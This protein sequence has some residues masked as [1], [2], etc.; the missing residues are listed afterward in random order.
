MRVLLIPLFLTACASPGYE[1]YLATQQAITQSRSHADT[2]RY[3]ALG[4]IAAKG[5]SAASVAAAMALALGGQSQ[6]PSIAPPQNEFIQWA[7]IL[8]PALGNAYAIGKSAD[9]SMRAS[10]NAYFT[11]AATTAGFVGIA[12]QI[13][14]PVIA[15]PVTPQAN[16]YNTTSTTMTGSTGVMGSGTYQTDQHNISGSYNPVTTYPTSVTTVGP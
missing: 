11:S 6:P 12:S 16:I 8:V 1:H 3:T 2:A 5:D 15:A 14:A 13:Q 7:A 9:V 10:D 4:A